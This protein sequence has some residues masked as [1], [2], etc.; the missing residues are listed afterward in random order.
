MSGI[1]TRV[2]LEST[3]MGHLILLLC[4]DWAMRVI[5]D[6]QQTHCE[7]YNS[8][9]SRNISKIELYERCK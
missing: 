8:H 4:D 2:T 3:R 5:I 1:T 7:V 6:T 9:L